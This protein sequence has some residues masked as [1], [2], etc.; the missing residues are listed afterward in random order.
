MCQISKIIQHGYSTVTNLQRYGQILQK[1]YCFIFPFLSPLS[2]F[3]LFSS[4]SLSDFLSLLPVPV[5][6][7]FD[8]SRLF[9]GSDDSVAPTTTAR[10]A[11]LVL[12]HAR[13]SPRGR[14]WSHPLPSPFCPPFT[15]P[16]SGCGFFFCCNLGWSDGG[17]GLWAVGGD[18]GNG[19]G[20]W[21]W[22]PVVAV[23][24]VDGLFRLGLWLFVVEFGWI[25]LGLL[26]VV[27]LVVEDVV[28]VWWWLCW[29]LADGC[30]LCWWVVNIILIC[31]KY[32]FN[33]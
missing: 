14:H 2:S 31:S 25:C 27:F 18:N 4:L 9:T 15:L 21:G 32:Y 22:W 12:S 28:V 20:L 7:L 23:G 19:G 11:T 30:W 26:W 1:F 13:F 8:Q 29:L 3:L 24:V 17:G 5:P 10:S 6:S 16:L 33:V